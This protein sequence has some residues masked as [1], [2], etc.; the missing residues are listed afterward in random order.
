[1]ELESLAMK[2]FVAVFALLIPA[3]VNAQAFVG[4]EAPAADSFSTAN[5][6]DS[7]ASPPRHESPEVR[8]IKLERALAL[9]DEAAKLLAA[10]GGKFTRKNRE[11]VLRQRYAILT[12]GR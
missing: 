2:I 12:Y 5:F 4:I 8:Q 6:V 3:T 7:F 9:R 11:Y 1:L 10:D